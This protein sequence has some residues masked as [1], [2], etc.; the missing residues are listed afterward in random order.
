MTRCLE[1]Q[2]PYF[3]E[4]L[5]RP[6]PKHTNTCVT[7]AWNQIIKQRRRIDVS[8]D[9][10]M[11]TALQHGTWMDTEGFKKLVSRRRKTGEASTS[12]STVHR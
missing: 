10:N 12:I 1:I 8:Y 7:G 4:I 11:A 9:P 6:L 3:R 2:G 5:H